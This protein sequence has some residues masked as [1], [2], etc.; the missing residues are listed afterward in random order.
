[1]EPIA[2]SD[3]AARAKLPTIFDSPDGPDVSQKSHWAAIGA[4]AQ[5]GGIQARWSNAG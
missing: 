5:T 4:T 1:M 3:V 2:A